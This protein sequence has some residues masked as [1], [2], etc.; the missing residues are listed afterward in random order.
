M[1][2]MM[3]M[4]VLTLITVT[5]SDSNHGS[6]GGTTAANSVANRAT[7]P[8]KIVPAQLNPEP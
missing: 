1:M 7:A 2:M 5:G 4:L 8:R 3:M 6:I